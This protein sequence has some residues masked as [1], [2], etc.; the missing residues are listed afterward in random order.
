MLLEELQESD[1]PHRTTIRK[2]VEEVLSEHLDEL[3]K[4]MAVRQLPL[5]ICLDIY[6][7]NSD[8]RAKSHLPWICGVTQTCHHSWL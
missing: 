1:I 4:E 2:R 7:S 6:T 5:C 3:E 8:R